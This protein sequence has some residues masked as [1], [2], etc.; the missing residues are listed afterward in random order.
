MA[1]TLADRL[2]EVKV[3]KVGDTLTDLKAAFEVTHWPVR[4]QRSKPRQL[5]K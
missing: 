1:N 3:R 4:W 5:A 2:A